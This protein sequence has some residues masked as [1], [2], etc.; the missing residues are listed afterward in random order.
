MG[1][2]AA[3]KLFHNNWFRRNEEH[4]E[5]TPAEGQLITAALGQAPKRWSGAPDVERMAEILADEPAVLDRIGAQLLQVVIGMKGCGAAVQLL[6]DRGVPLEINETEY[7]VLHEAA[8]GGMA[9]TLRAVF[10]SGAADATG[11]SVLKPHTGWPDNLSLMYWAACGGHAE[12]AKLL[13]RYGVGV[14]HELPIKGNGERGTTSLQEA[15]APSHWGT[16]LCRIEGKRQVARELIVDGA[17]YDVYSACGLNDTDRVREL[18]DENP[19]VVG[20]TED[21]GMTPLHWAARAGAMECATIL[22]AEEA[23]VN[24]LNRAN[25]TPLQL[26][27][28]KG[29]ADMVHLLAKHGADLNT[30]DKKGRPPL[31]RAMYEGRVAAAEAL[32]AAGAAPMVLN[33][34]GKNAFEIARKD[35]R[36]FRA[37]A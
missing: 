37:L 19:A 30:Q 26:A 5:L 23:D 21:Y 35:A 9:D 36:H 29:Q 6:L 10:E 7:N 33:K 14:H 25:R 32:L 16:D 22:V 34:R 20:V 24:A 12:V 15:V 28:E 8:W 1:T 18:V 2:T 27:A 11:V 31:H 4:L 17:Y 13:I 3:V